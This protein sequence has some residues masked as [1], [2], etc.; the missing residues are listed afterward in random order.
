MNILF[1]TNRLVVLCCTL[2]VGSMLFLSSCRK[3]DAT[4]QPDAGS[5]EA[6]NRWALDTMRYY[7]LWNDDIPADNALDFNSEPANFFSS[8]LTPLDRQRSFSRIEEDEDLSAESAELVRTN[9][10]GIAGALQVNQE[11]TIGLI[12]G[13]VLNDSPAERAGLLR[14][15]IITAV[16]GEP[17]QV[18]NGSVS[19]SSLF[20]EQEVAI[21]YGRWNEERDTYVLQDD[22]PVSPAVID[23][24]AIL[25]D[26]IYTTPG[27]K[28]VAYLAY[29]HFYNAQYQPLLDVFQDFKAEQVDE[30]ILD[31]RYNS[32]GGV[33]IAS[34][35]AGLV[36]AN[37]NEEEI[38]LKY[39]YNSNFEDGESSFRSYYTGS[40]LG[41]SDVTSIVK[42]N[43]LNLSKV[44][45]LATGA[46]ASAS[47]LI[48]N[49][50]RP[51]LGDAN[52]VHI[53]E[54]T[55]G[56]NVASAPFDDESG[57]ISW[58]LHPTIAYVYN[59]DG[60]GD[61][62]NGLIPT[63]MVDEMDD[64]PLKPIGALEDP[65]IATAI[66]LIEPA[67]RRG[68]LGTI[69]RPAASVRNIGTKLN[70]ERS[71]RNMVMTDGDILK[72]LNHH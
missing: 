50:L 33:A 1:T 58:V 40:A 9:G 54:T 57:E 4:P 42:A 70:L 18:N 48:I 28:K 69:E 26:S 59:K 72:H 45:V 35:L 6:I 43:N 37:F 29:N 24:Q 34:V 16:D 63:R 3:S 66:S 11:G 12:I 47:E 46:S 8:L 14:G 55:Y 22:I 31:L 27:G 64:L 20:Q 25:L 68:L 62:S 60:E 49:N 7:Y 65:L 39:I 10:L 13:Y 21:R 51:F 56:K 44:Y 52:V 36:M 2:L 30:L 23:E 19:F 5:N 71:G 41:S 15:D 38:F 53:G 67:S 17:F 61:Y 32:G